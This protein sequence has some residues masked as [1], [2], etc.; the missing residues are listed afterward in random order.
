MGF[1]FFAPSFDNVGIVI[2]SLHQIGKF[3][4]LVTIVASTGFVVD[5]QEWRLI[6]AIS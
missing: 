4:H 5:S 1:F 6:E 3:A 2:L